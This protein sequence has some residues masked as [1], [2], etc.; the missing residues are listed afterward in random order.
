MGL[1]RLFLAYM[2]LLSHAGVRIATY[3]GGVFAVIVFYLISGYVMAGLL[4]RH[5]A[6]PDRVPM[7]YADRML[8][9]FPQYLAYAG[10]TLAWFWWTGATT[11]FLTRSP[12]ALDLLNNLTVIPLNF[13]MYNGADAFTLIP[14]G[15]SLGAELQFYLVVP[16]MLLWPRVGVA[17]AA[18]SLGLQ[19]AAWHGVL[20]TDWYGYRLLAGVLWVF[21]LGMVMFHAHRHRPALA[22]ALAWGAPVLALLV[23]LYLRRLGLHTA[24][25]HQEVL[26]GW[27]I[28]APLLHWA[29]RFKGGRIDHVAGDVSYGVFLNHF[30]LLWLLF[31]APD[32]TPVQLALLALCSFVLS[33]ATQRWLERPVLAWRRRLRTGAAGVPQSVT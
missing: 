28:G 1:L 24:P 6:R 12:T 18:V 10:A 9:L 15:W 8:R 13:F 19:V 20:N 23:Y 16:I 32:R 33:W 14:P 5:Y 2:V 29:G 22:T 27:G 4:R 30:L 26:L 11:D 7:F 3:N 31:P 25:Y 17:M 21:G